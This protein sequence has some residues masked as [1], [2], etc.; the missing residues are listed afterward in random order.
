MLKN[1][2]TLLITILLTTNVFANGNTIANYASLEDLLKK[3]DYPSFFFLIEKMQLNPKDYEAFLKNQQDS[4]HIPIYWLLSE[5]YARENKPIESQKWLY[6]ASITTRQDSEICRDKT[7]SKAT[8]TLF[9]Y[10]KFPVEMAQQNSENN[11]KIMP[12]VIFYVQNIKKRSNPSWACVYGDFYKEVKNNPVI[13]EQYWRIQRNK[14][15]N[16]FIS[17]QGFSN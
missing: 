16:K 15:L 8:K 17:E 3:E 7:S 4:G 12:D 9:N 6:I 11:S 2:I 13:D 10:F 14:T 5:M 1:A